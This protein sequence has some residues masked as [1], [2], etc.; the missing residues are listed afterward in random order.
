[1]QAGRLF[2]MKNKN[3]KAEPE[4]SRGL[5]Y[6]FLSGYHATLPLAELRAVLEAEKYRYSVEV[7]LDQLALFRADRPPLG[8]AKRAGLVHE[9]GFYIGV[10]EPFLEDLARLFRET[11]WKSVLGENSFYVS[12]TRV[13]GV[14]KH[15]DATSA[16]RVL[17]GIVVKNTGLKVSKKHGKA[18][19]VFLVEGIAVVG[20]RLEEQDR[21]GFAERRPQR[22]PFFKPGA[23]DPRL[24]RVFVNL[25][26]V[27]RG[28]FYYDPFCGTGGFAVEALKI[29]LNV[30]CSDADRTMAEGS[31]RNLRFY[32]EPYYYEC[33]QADATR[34]PLRS[35][36]VDGIGT[37]PPYGR[38]TTTK[39]MRVRD[40]I[41]GFLGEALEVLKKKG[42]V[43]F[44][45]PHW[46]D[47][48]LLALNTGLQ[49]V[50]K[51]YMRV[52]GS[53]TRLIVVALKP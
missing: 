37:D 23:L 48:E 3:S 41:E 7:L 40:V 5:Y 1:M 15:L 19:R 10:S 4:Y 28:G 11:N 21:R 53:L 46:V 43:V 29:G 49:V 12:F 45:S 51:H 47:S 17:G 50:E 22:K 27:P 35:R 9:V 24:S 14:S 42:Y 13:R 33:F 18:I 52:H 30:L 16:A 31:T 34:I 39:G 25:A 36:L 38:S 8:I 2:S 20:V 44:A 6:A 26:R 32:E